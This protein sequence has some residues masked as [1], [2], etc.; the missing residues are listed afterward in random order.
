[1]SLHRRRRRGLVS[2]A[3]AKLRNFGPLKSFLTT[4][5]NDPSWWGPH[6]VVIRIAF[7]PH[8]LLWPNGRNAPPSCTVF[9]GYTH[10]SP[11]PTCV[12]S[13]EPKKEMQFSMF[14]RFPYATEPRAPRHGGIYCCNQTLMINFTSHKDIKKCLWL[15]QD[16]S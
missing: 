8:L 11:V 12:M 10:F 6:S 9:S 2:A 4:L 13:Y 1:M 15:H 5:A 14:V 16:Y 7:G 3:P